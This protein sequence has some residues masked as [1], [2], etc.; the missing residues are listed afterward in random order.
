VN[1]IFS[2]LGKLF[3]IISLW[4]PVNSIIEFTENGGNEYEYGCFFGTKV[5]LHKKNDHPAYLSKRPLVS[6]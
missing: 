4:V 1:L 2:K 6:Y 5:S 3:I